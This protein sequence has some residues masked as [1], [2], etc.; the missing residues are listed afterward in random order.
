M[1]VVLF[2]MFFRREKGKFLRSMSR[3]NKQSPAFNHPC[4][5]SEIKIYFCSIFPGK[6]NV[7]KRENGKLLTSFGWEECCCPF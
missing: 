1:T 5:P 4:T 3:R 6:N 2:S 7:E